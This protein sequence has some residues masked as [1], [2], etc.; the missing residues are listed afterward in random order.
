VTHRLVTAAVL[1]LV[2]SAA[3]LRG[4]DAKKDLDKLQGAWAVTAMEANGKPVP[5]D[6]VKGTVTFKG[7]LMVVDGPG[8]GR[9]EHR[10]KLDPSKTPKALDATKTSE[11]GRDSLGIYQLE[12]DEMKLCLPIGLR[13][14]RPKDF[15]SAEGSNLVVMTLKRSKK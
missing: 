10:I 11:E 8:F 5:L 9:T 1:L 12:G 2:F 6:S 13:T 14:E 4:Q 15:K 3:A 7:D